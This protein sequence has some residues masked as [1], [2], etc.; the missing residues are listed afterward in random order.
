MTSETVV[1]VPM[2]KREDQFYYLL[3]RNLSCKVVGVPYQ[4]NATAFFVL[5]QEGG[6]EQVEKGLKEKTLRKWLKMSMK[7]YSSQHAQASLTCT[8]PTPPHPALQQ[9][10]AVGVGRTHLALELPPSPEALCEVPAPWP[11]QLGFLMGSSKWAVTL[12]DSLGPS[13]EEDGFHPKQWAGE[14]L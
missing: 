5:P 1:R 2:M 14:V 7:R 9:G 4:G 12:G 6:M 10:H 3:D 11:A 8:L 13:P